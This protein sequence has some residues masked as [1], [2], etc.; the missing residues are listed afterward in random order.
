[1]AGD[2]TGDVNAV[3]EPCEFGAGRRRENC[4]LAILALVPETRYNFPAVSSEI[5]LKVVW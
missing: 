1:M 4:D 2:F 3:L 5:R